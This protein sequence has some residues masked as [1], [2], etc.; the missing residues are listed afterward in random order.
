MSAPHPELRAEHYMIKRYHGT[1]WLYALTGP[2]GS[3]GTRVGTV[4][5]DGALSL[6]RGIEWVPEDLVEIGGLARR[7]AEARAA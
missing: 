3:N 1:D 6:H 5:A 2:V 4:L 7:W